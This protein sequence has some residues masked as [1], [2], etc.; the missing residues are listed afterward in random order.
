MRYSYVWDTDATA[1]NQPWRGHAKHADGA[2]P[3]DAYV[4]FSG[5][6]YGRFR[7]KETSI[8]YI[9]DGDEFVN[10]TM[11][12]A[13]AP[14]TGS[15]A[16][17]FGRVKPHLHEHVSTSAVDTTASRFHGASIA[18]LVVGAMGVF[19]FTVGLRHWLGE[20]RTAIAQEAS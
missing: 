8:V 17:I 16:T 20:R 13:H 15:E 11:W 5:K 6:V 14:P 4:S 3:D 7:R 19:V 12:D 10:V 18:G 1:L 9:R 2:W